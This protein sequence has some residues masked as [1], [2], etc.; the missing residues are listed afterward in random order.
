M[1]EAAPQSLA[2]RVLDHAAA[3]PEKRAIVCDGLVISYLNLAER[4]ERCAASLQC[5]GMIP[6]GA[7]TVGLLSAPSIDHAV[8][9]L[10]CQLAGVALVPLPGLVAAEDLGKMIDDAGIALI[11]HDNAHSQRLIDAQRS[12][13]G[14]ATMVPIGHDGETSRLDGWI[15]EHAAPFRPVTLDDQWMSDLIYSSGTTGMPKGIAQSYRARREQCLG[16]GNLGMSPDTC[17]FQSVGLYSNYGLS[18]LLLSLWWGGTFFAMSKFSADEAVALLARERIDMAWVPPATLMRIV[19]HPAFAA[20]VEGKPALKLSA[21][22]PLAIEQKLRVRAVWPGPFID[23]YGQTET[24]TLSM[25]HADSAPSDKLGSVGKILPTVAVKIVDEDGKLMPTGAEGEIIG[26][27][28]TMMAG[29][30]RRDDANAVVY[31]HDEDGR[32]FV[33]T[34]DIGRIDADGYLWLCDRKKD[35]IIS[36]GY[37]IYPADIERVLSSHP[38]VLECA[39]VGCPSD[40]WGESPVAFVSLREGEVT[41]GDAL[42]DWVNSRVG[43]VQRLA[44]TMVLDALPNGA[45]GKIL[46]RD[47]RDKYAG[48]IGKLP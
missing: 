31:W 24:G 42:R 46:K 5:L 32:A 2:Q 12:I 22:A 40:R 30:H 1:S 45:M 7:P 14:P 16:L 26:H 29:Y 21:G 25:L 37:N 13:S 11:F 35:M 8:V 19:D 47:L 20:A 41:D 48:S 15:H 39:V 17:L 36:G 34:G 38:A 27:T 6:G 4:A 3:T 18:S 10:A 44:A 43:A 23:L 28:N 33:R 9:T